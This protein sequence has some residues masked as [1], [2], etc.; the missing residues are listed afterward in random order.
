MNGS[1]AEILKNSSQEI[2]ACWETEV[3]KII[4]PA[5]L[6]SP[7]SLRDSIPDFLNDLIHALET[8]FKETSKDFLSFAHKHGRERANYSSYSI[9][10]AI[11]EYN[12]LRRVIFKELENKCQITVRDRDLI[13]EAIS[14]ALAKAGAEYAKTQ[15]KVVE[16]LHERIRLIT[17]IQPTLIVYLDQDMNYVFVNNTF[18]EWFKMDPVKIIGKNVADVFPEDFF[19][20]LKEKTVEA[21]K[22][23]T[24]HFRHYVDYPSGRKFVDVTYKPHLAHD[25]KVRGIFVSV[26]DLT[27]IQETITEL[28]RERDLRDKFVSTLSHDLRTPL[29]ASK[30]S[31]Q[32]IARKIAD[33]SIHTHTTRIVENINRADKLIQDLLD[34]GRIRAGKMSL[35]ETEE[36]DLIQLINTTL[37]DLTTIHGER[38]TLISPEKLP[39]NLYREGIRRILENLCTNA[40]KY[41]A[42]YETVKVTVKKDGE[43]F[44]LSVCNKGN[45]LIHIDREKLF[46]PF[47]QGQVNG[48]TGWGIGLTIVKGITEAHGGT[49]LVESDQETIFKVILPLDASPFIEN[50]LH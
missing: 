41:G 36:F 5:K 16:A 28:E 9:E 23:K 7:S 45:P 25:G 47:E 19:L 42:T 13:Y 43:R 12:I 1:P 35:P 6:E 40:I 3:R 29:T 15:I 39:V 4:P 27:E 10:D 8:N 32:I 50:H 18:G 11:T 49:V 21:F 46:E 26:H 20:K 44:I 14:L 48:R 24:V 30:M 37:E 31:A 22:G 2:L 33:S 17:D 38:F 34:A